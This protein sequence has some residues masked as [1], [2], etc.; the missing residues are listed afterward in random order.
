M[1][2][3]TKRQQ[4][5]LTLIE[6]HLALTGSPPTRAEIAKRMGF[7][8]PNAA[9]DHLRA[10]ARKG[11]IELIPGTSRGIRLAHKPSGIPI[12][13][14]NQVQLSQPIF[15]DEHLEAGAQAIDRSIFSHSVDYFLRIAKSN[16]ELAIQEGDLLAIHQGQQA[17]P[18][19]IVL[20]RTNHEIKVRQLTHEQIHPGLIE[21]VVVGVIRSLATGHDE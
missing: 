9:E 14:A 3:L 21:G 5:I 13:S 2:K 12:I 16:P 10:L 11:V 4:E 20:I 6:S 15:S 8:S 18:G 17:K 7:K 19:Q 1:T